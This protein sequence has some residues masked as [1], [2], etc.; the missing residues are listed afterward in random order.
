MNR[1]F[2]ISLNKWA[3]Y[4]SIL[5]LIVAVALLPFIYGHISIRLPINLLYAFVV[6]FVLFC[7]KDICLEVLKP[8]K[9]PLFCMAVVMVMAC[10]SLHYALDSKMTIQSMRQYLFEPFIF[11]MGAYLLLHGLNEREAKVFYIL[12][13]FALC[14]H[15]FATI[16]DF[17]V[18]GHGQF[19]YRATF[20]LYRIAQTIYV[21]YLLFPLG[22]A[23]MMTLLS[24][25]YVR[26]LC[27]V[28]VCVCYG[29][30]LCNGGRFGILA[31]SLMLLCP[32]VFCAYRYKKF[33]L[34]GIFAFILGICALIYSLSMH[35]DKRFNFAYTI[36]NF[37]KVWDTPPAAMGKYWGGCT[38]KICPPASL[39]QDSNI[40]IDYSSL[41]RISLLKT[42]ILA[43]VNNPLRPNGYHFQ[44]FPRNINAIFPLDSQNHYFSAHYVY[45]NHSYVT[46]VWFELG[47]VGFLGV[48]CFVCFIFYRFASLRIGLKGLGR[49]R[50]F[51]CLC[52]AGGIAFG[53]VGL[54]V[55]NFFDCIPIRDGQLVL[56]VLFGVCL[57]SLERAHVSLRR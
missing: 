57:A 26:W 23:I 53:L 48:A 5:L 46:S 19:G 27:F 49:N 30:L 35:W 29:A 36:D 52:M 16:Y 42:T 33:I 18:Y 44:Q 47:V 55:S 22:L 38:P 28:F 7:Y 11:M 1:D 12:L 34:L 15:P 32:F 37:A 56:F 9:F 3:R 21:F 20:S 41:V 14:Y 6:I 31:G 13:F 51:W 40:R 10:I 43:I 45:H 8:L 24:Q 54:I 25:S 39:V 4:V 50:E 17:F 2:R